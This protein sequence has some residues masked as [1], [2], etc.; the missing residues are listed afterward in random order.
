[1]GQKQRVCVIG[2]GFGG[3]YAAQSLKK[4]DV[5]I[6]LIDRRNFHLFQPLL[7]QVATGG[8]SPGDISCPL[9]FVFRGQDNVR[10]ILGDV[11]GFDVP[12]KKIILSDSECAYDTLVVALGAQNSYFGKNEWQQFAPGLKSIEEATE[13]R[14]RIFFAFEMAEKQQDA[15]KRTEWLT[16]VVVGA[17]PTGV[18]LAG[19]LGEICRDT[20]KDNFRVI[21]PEEARIILVDGNDRILSNFPPDLSKSAEEQLIDLNVRFR[22]KMRVTAMDDQGVTMQGERGVE[23]INSRTV[24]W[25]AGVAPSPLGRKLAEQTGAE[26]SKG[27]HIHVQPDCSIKDHPEIY[28]IGDMAWFDGKDGKPLPG[29]APVAIQQGKYVADAITKR[30]RGEE[31]KPFEYWDK[32][33]LA[34]IGRK[35]GVAWIGRLHFSGMLAWMAWLFIHLFYLINFQ[36]RV[37]VFLQWG[38]QYFTFNRGARLITGARK[39]MEQVQWKESNTVTKA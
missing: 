6:T 20:L 22:P 18:E 5:E 27:G 32:G 25:A 21:D 14:H 28:V 4:S 3:L 2:G 23:R 38:F 36:N 37:L 11:I 15:Q 19:T 16:F 13:I 17:G 1:M 34:T 10:V 12:N 33:T 30:L 26:T 24:L 31:V 39:M 35:S 9:R 8:L 7:Y 29:V